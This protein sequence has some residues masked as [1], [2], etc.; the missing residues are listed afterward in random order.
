MADQ[1]D[2]AGRLR[3]ARRGWLLTLSRG[4]VRVLCVPFEGSASEMYFE[5]HAV[6]REI[7]LVAAAELPAE[8]AARPVLVDVTQPAALRWSGNLPQGRI[9]RS[10]PTAGSSLAERVNCRPGC[11]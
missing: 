9:S 7:A 11:R 2:R 8:P 5:G 6:F 3:T 10:Y 1:S 4:N